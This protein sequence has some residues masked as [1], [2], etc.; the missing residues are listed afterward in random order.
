MMKNNK[1]PYGLIIIFVLLAAGFIIAG[2]LY[3]HNNEIQ[4]KIEMGNKLTAIAE[5][6]INDIRQW[7]L[8]RLGDANTLYENVVFSENVDSFLRNP[9]DVI[10]SDQLTIWLE[11]FQSSYQYD[12]VFL[13]DSQGINRLSI[14]ALDRS[15]GSTNFPHFSEAFE[16]GQV[17]FEDFY[18]DEINQQIYLAILIPIVSEF[19]NRQPLGVLVLRI[20]PQ[21]YLYPFISRW[22]EPSQT[23]ETLIVRKEGEEVV[24]LNDLKYQD[25]T[26]LNLRFPLT[27]SDL[28]AVKAVLG[29]QGITEGIDYRGVP[30][31][32]YLNKIPDSPW[33]L[34]ARIDIAEIYAPLNTKLW[35]MIAVVS[36]LVFSAAAGIGFVWR[37]QRVRFYRQE[38]KNIRAL[39][40]S[41]ERLRLAIDAA[42]QGFYDHNL[43]TGEIK[44]SP[45]YCHMLGY[46]PEQLQETYDHWHKRIHPDD[47]ILVKNKFDDFITG[48]QQSFQAE[49]RMLTSVGEWVWVLSLGKIV[50]WT[51]DGRPLRMLG[52]HTNINELKLTEEQLRNNQLWLKMAESTAHLGHWNLEI[53]TGTYTWSDE[54]YKI[55]GVD[56]LSFQPTYAHA[57]EIIHP[58]DREY[59]RQVN[60][61][62]LQEGKVDFEYR[63]IRP[64]GE[65]RY[66]TGTGEVIH[67]QAG[68]P[69]TIFGTLL[70][71]TELKQKERELEKKNQDLERFTY[72]I[73][74]DLKSPLVTVKTFLGYL[75]QDMKNNIPDRVEQD[76]IYIRNAVDKMGLLLNELLEVSRIGR[77]VNPSVLIPYN[78]IVN[79]ALNMVAGR[80]T[81]RGVD[82][83]AD[84]EELL[85]FGDHPRLVELWQNLIENA[86]KFMGDQ[87]QP[88]IELG[89]D[90]SDGK[91][92]FYV[93]DNGVGIASR[94]QEKVFGLFEKLDPRSEGTG[95]GLSLVKRI[96]DLYQGVVWVESQGVGLGACF[97]FTLPDALRKPEEKK[98]EG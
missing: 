58:D 13:L 62:I 11:R 60:A 97:K 84:Q 55:Y 24:F 89:V 80:I 96:V 76:K 32:A 54:V 74:H 50:E 26:A 16:S 68:E 43:V 23:A 21:Q 77:F 98:H 53:P 40:E 31:L 78:D 41:E 34:V 92:A 9:G 15:Y 65:T 17:I 79:E 6:K 27:D 72:M 8:E 22:P 29:W 48:K 52:T 3:Y 73:S 69:I 86:A 85:L 5:L 42:K 47:K 91:I 33:N 36:A 82:I 81:E 39:Q 7:R 57:L 71:T 37:Q 63:L 10:S 95:I 93:R 25:D 88:R 38:I 90:H 12:H 61:K 94:Y 28:P 56:P 64:G 44:L 49:Y 35:E 66:V 14:P 87:Q 51:A 30:V 45:E 59:R 18:R 4:Y 67:N 20:D 75:E 1:T 19:E 70:D 2:Y 46:E 83:R